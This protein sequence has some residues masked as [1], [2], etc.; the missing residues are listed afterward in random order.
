MQLIEDA[1][2]SPVYDFF[3]LFLKYE[4]GV[5]VSIHVWVLCFILLVYMSV[6]EPYW[7]ITMAL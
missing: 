4:M 3:C 2:F 5:V 1:I 6:P 7:F